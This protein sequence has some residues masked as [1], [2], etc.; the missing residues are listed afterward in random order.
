MVKISYE[1]SKSILK[2]IEE[3]LNI[4]GNASV[5]NLEYENDIELSLI[6]DV[7]NPHC[8]A[9]KRQIHLTISQK[10]I[11]NNIETEEGC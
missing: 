11:E 8:D 2:K 10:M 1:V 7:I 6:E 3:I 9:I 4:C 5:Q